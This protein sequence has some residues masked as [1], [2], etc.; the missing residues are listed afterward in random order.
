MSHD[1][2]STVDEY[3]FERPSDFDYQTYEEFMSN[4]LSVLSRRAR[5]WSHLLGSKETV[6]RGFKVKRYIRKGIPMKHRGKV[7]FLKALILT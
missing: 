7:R 2:Y 1:L 3:G 5:K 6:G 4:Y